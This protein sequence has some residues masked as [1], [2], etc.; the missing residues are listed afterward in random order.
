MVRLAAFFFA[1]SAMSA[2]QTARLTAFG[3]SKKCLFMRLFS[4]RLT[5]NRPAVVR[6]A[7]CGTTLARYRVDCQA[8]YRAFCVLHKT[9][10]RALCKLTLYR[11]G[12]K[13]Y[14]LYIKI[15]RGNIMAV[16]ARKRLNNDKYNA[17]CT[18]I[19]LKPLTPEANA[20]KAAAKASG[21]SIQGYIL[22]AVRER[23]AKEGQP[24]TLDDLP[25]ADSAGGD[26]VKP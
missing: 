15:N 11:V 17:K 5:R 1:H 2:A 3:S 24:L 16:S 19:N 9:L 14:I 18:Q 22:Q 25:G 12:R 20:I 23:M 8:L 21:Q 26:S 4:F 7:C 6:L 13:C 10:Y